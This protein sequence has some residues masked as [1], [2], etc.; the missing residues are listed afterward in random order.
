MKQV[1]STASLHAYLESRGFTVI[2]T[3]GGCQAYHQYL[4]DDREYEVLITHHESPE[5]PVYGE[6]IRATLFDTSNGDMLGDV[7][8]NDSS[9]T[10]A[11]AMHFLEYTAREIVGEIQEYPIDNP[12]SGRMRLSDDGQTAERRCGKGFFT[13]SVGDMFTSIWDDGGIYEGHRYTVTRL[14]NIGND[15]QVY[16]DNDGYGFFSE[17]YP[18]NV[19]HRTEYR[20][21]D[22]GEE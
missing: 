4:D 11:A 20:G 19:I 12:C 22:Y 7:F 16:H 2:D 14:E 21:A 3:G 1:T 15:I 10:L 9:G 18:N 6:D 8:V 5:L 17:I 13:L